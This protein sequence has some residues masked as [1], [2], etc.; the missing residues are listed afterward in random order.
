MIILFIEGRPIPY[1]SP[2]MYRN[3]CFNP[4]SAKR[5][6]I[7]K[8]IRLQYTGPVIEKSV[9]VE[10]V[11]SFVIPKGFTKAQVQRIVDGNDYFNKRPDTS[12][13][14]KFFDDCLIDTVIKD[15]SL[16]VEC[17]IKKRYSSRQGTLVMI[18]EVK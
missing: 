6:Q 12:N 14:V 1:Q 5:R 15:D 13:M 11:F 4:L 7:Q 10:Y 16:I 9:K 8:E 2:R 3:V 17:K 18:E